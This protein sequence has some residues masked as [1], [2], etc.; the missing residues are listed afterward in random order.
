[1]KIKLFTI[2]FS[3]LAL[4]SCS[5]N[6]EAKMSIS[7]SLWGNIDEKE[8]SIYTLTNKNGML[9]R[10]T[11]YGGIIVSIVVPDKNGNFEN[12]VLGFDSLAPYV[13]ENPYFGSIV[14]RYGNRI[15]K[16]KFSLNGE[17]YSLA[18]NNGINHLHGGLKGFNKRVWD[19]DNE[20]S[21]ND[22]VGLTLSYLSRD[23]EEGY[24]GNLKIKV[25]YVL[26]NNNEI[27]IRYEAETDKATVLNPTNHSYFNLS[28]CKKT[29]LDHEL[30]IVADS[31]TPT[32]STLIPTGEVIAVAGTGFDFSK[33]HTIGERIDKIEGGYDIN[34]KLRKQNNELSMAAEVYEPTSGRLLQV[35]TAEPGIQFYSGNFLDGSNVGS[36]GVK[37]EKYFGFCLETQHFPDSPNQTNFPNVVLNPGEKYAHL[38]IYKFSTR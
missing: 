22:S 30:T 27:V 34:Y 12:V 24:P 9:V 14:G 7:S 37:Y 19:V 20:F 1:M 35:F 38:A 18:V 25:N 6:K 16:G 13:A 29:I 26:T 11:N 28:A 15:A 33:A 32:D 17:Q 21:N 23:L 4:L 2:L 31:I 10:I 36:G 8:I 3:V 5:S